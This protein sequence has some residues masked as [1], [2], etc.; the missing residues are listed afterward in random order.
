MPNWMRE[1]KHLLLSVIGVLTT[2]TGVVI[3]ADFREV[4]ADTR[5][6]DKRIDSVCTRTTILEEN[7][8]AIKESKEGDIWLSI[9]LQQ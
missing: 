9:Q 2:I 7:Y 8:K 1:Y 5:I 3:W 6:N 4:K